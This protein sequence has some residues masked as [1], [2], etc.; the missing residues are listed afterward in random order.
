MLDRIEGQKSD[1]E[2]ARADLEKRVEARTRELATSNKELEAFSYSVSHDLRAP[3]RAI[4]GFGKALLDHC[5]PSLDEK[6]RH[7]LQRVR[8]GT[9]RMG[10]LIDDMLGLARISRKELTRQRVD[11]SAIAERVAADLA[12]RDG[13]KRVHVVVEAGLTATADSG[14]V[15]VLLENLMGNAWKFSSRK[16]DPRVQVGRLNG[17]GHVFYVRDNGAGFDMAYADKLF[18]AFQRLHSDSEFEGTGIGLATVQR[19]VNRHGGRVWAE[20]T[21]NGGATF[22]FTLP[23]C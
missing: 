10:D 18:G 4:D 8:A 17:E 9:R 7:Y 1:L 14:L 5:G 3:L 20:G 16:D 13:G 19:I 6:G 15:E 22:F 21:L 23:N 12:G 2:H 11:V